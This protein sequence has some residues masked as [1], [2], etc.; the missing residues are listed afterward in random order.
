MAAVVCGER[1]IAA[2][3]VVLATGTVP[4][5]ALARAAGLRIG[6]SGAVW[7]GATSAPARPGY[8]PRATAPRCASA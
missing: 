3:L 4:R 2:D 6:A 8:T 1:A 7:V 5:L